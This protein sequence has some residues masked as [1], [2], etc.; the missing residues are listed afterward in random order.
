VIPVGSRSAWSAVDPAAAR[1]STRP[2]RLLIVTAIVIAFVA[3]AAAAVIYHGHS[4]DEQ[5]AADGYITLGAVQGH[6]VWAKITDSRIFV[7]IPDGKGGDLC[8]S[9]GPFSTASV[10]LCAD[11][12]EGDGSVFVAVAPP[13]A[14]ATIVTAGGAELPATLVHGPGWANALAVRVADDDSLFGASLQR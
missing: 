4:P 13:S 10:P 5:Y 3:I 1:P 14:P 11:A 9:S 7:H 6:D 8:F 12:F 2:R